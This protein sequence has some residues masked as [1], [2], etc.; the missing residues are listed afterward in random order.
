MSLVPEDHF[1]NRSFTRRYDPVSTT[2]S[3]DIRVTEYGPPD[4][5]KQEGKAGS[6]PQPSEKAP[7]TDIPFNQS[8]GLFFFL[9]V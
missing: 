1:I 7:P 2:R 6:G 3:G 5:S 4:S 8:E 9:L